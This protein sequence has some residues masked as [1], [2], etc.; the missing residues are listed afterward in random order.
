MYADAMGSA[1]SLA[2]IEVEYEETIFKIRKLG[3]PS[4]LDHIEKVHVFHLDLE[5]YFEKWYI[6]IY[7]YLKD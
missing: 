7:N 3:T 6:D 5:D 1:A 4:Y 2:L